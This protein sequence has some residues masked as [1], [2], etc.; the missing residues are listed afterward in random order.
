M[1]RE[2]YMRVVWNLESGQEMLRAQTAVTMRFVHLVAAAAVQASAASA[3][4]GALFSTID[5]MRQEAERHIDLLLDTFKCKH[6]YIDVGTHAGVQLRK[7]FEPAKYSDAPVHQI[8]EEYFPK[9]RCGVCAIGFEPSPLQQSVLDWLEANYTQVGIGVHIFRAAAAV[10]GGALSFG[11]G[12]TAGHVN[13][14]MKAG[15]HTSSSYKYVPAM[16]LEHIVH[17]VRSALEK[18]V[19]TRLVFRTKPKIVMKIDVEAQEWVREKCS[20]ISSQPNPS[21]ATARAHTRFSTTLNHSYSCGS[22]PHVCGQVIMPQLILSET[23]CKVNA[24]YIE[25]HW[26]VERP[27]FFEW[28]RTASSSLKASAE[29]PHCGSKLINL[30]D[31]TYATDAQPWPT[32]NVC[33]SPSPWPAPS[34]R[35]RR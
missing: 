33:R 7:L 30:D 12:G 32:V 4:D 24:V 35:P 31:E 23:I 2:A 34:S 19:S 5:N 8:F 15:Q 10:A 26:F 18:R 14:G 25:Y 16:S 3:S 22:D 11:G 9:N 27:W 1:L 29:A 28:A 21:D 20:R 17:Y 6:F 13:I